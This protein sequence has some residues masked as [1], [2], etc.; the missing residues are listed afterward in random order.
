MSNHKHKRKICRTCKFITELNDICR[1][2]LISIVDL[3]GSTTMTRRSFLLIKQ[4]QLSMCW[5]TPN[6]KLC[7]NSHR[8][9]KPIFFVL[10]FCFVCKKQTNWSFTFS[11]PCEHAPTNELATSTRAMMTSIWDPNWS[12]QRESWS[13]QTI[14][15]RWNILLS[16]QREKNFD[17]ATTRDCCWP[18][19]DP[20]SNLASCATRQVAH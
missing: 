18:W 17:V 5:H 14:D 12:R 3:L 13:T 11:V 20:C 4:T 16:K 8:S 7:R 9:N 10:F 19:R 15:L 1:H 2:T 6:C